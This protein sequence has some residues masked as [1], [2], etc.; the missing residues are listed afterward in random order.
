[1]S[2]QNRNREEKDNEEY[3]KNFTRT[4]NI[5]FVSF[6]YL[7]KEEKHLYSTLKCLYWDAKPRF[8]SLRELSQ[9]TDFSV[10][11]LSKMLP[12]LHKCG[13]IHAEIKR[14]KDKKGKE[15]GNP[16][17]HITILDIW[18]LNRAYFAAPMEARVKLDPSLELVHEKE[19]DLAKPV[20]KNVQACSPN[21][22]SLFTK[23]NKV[24]PFGE[25]VQAQIERAKDINKDTLKDITKKESGNLEK[26]GVEINSQLSSHTPT[27]TL[28]EKMTELEQAFWT[29]WCSMAFNVIAPKLTEVAYGHVQALAPHITTQEQLNSLVEYSRQKLVNAK[30]DGTVH[31]GNLRNDLNE[32]KQ[33]EASSTPKIEDEETTLENQIKRATDPN[34]VW[35]NGLKVFTP[36]PSKPTVT[37]VEPKRELGYVKIAMKECLSLFANDK[38]DMEHLERADDL[39]QQGGLGPY[40]FRQLVEKA[41]NTTKMSNVEG[42]RMEYFFSRLNNLVIKPQECSA[43]GK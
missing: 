15:I 14:E 37:E 27:S 9:Q 43:V 35:S 5:I 40:Q 3:N 24:V 29:L 28:L 38:P 16:K 33:K 41:V 8:V 30:K 34:K 18:E 21:N 7:T 36:K 20:H 32:W 13:L 26:I 6:K 1:M 22:T 17:Y 11:A 39:R 23:K 2:I 25:Q 19:Q 42:D 10:S 4:P 31:L 12:R